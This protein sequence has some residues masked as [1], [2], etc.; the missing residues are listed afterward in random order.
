MSGHVHLPHGRGICGCVSAG[1]ADRQTRADTHPRVDVLRLV[2]GLLA[3]WLLLSVAVLDGTNPLVAVKDIL[4][5]GLLLALTVAAAA[6]GRARRAESRVCM[7]LGVLLIAGSVLLEFGP[8]PEA[9]ARQW[10]EVVVGV[11]LVCLGAARVR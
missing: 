1:G 5:G 9:V 2:Q 8:G 3:L 4:V 7:L 11:L 10:N 6:E